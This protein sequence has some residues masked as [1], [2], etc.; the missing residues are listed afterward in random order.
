MAELTQKI[1][2][3]DSQIDAALAEAD[4]VAQDVM[5]KADIRAR[6]L[7]E[8][9]QKLFETYN[10][11]EFSALAEELE[12]ERQQAIAVLQQK[13]KRFDEKFDINTVADQLLDLA[14]ER[15]CL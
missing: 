10:A 6:E 3:L 4:I 9:Q 1:I 7:I 12:S 5:K 14:K 13:M 11:N 2:D 15:V 8:E